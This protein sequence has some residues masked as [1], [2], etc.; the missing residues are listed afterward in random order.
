[1]FISGMWCALANRAG[2]PKK[3]VGRIS[4]FSNQSTVLGAFQ[5]VAPPPPSN[6][7]LAL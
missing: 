2:A 3:A 4:A 1:M 6:V 5:P 7:T